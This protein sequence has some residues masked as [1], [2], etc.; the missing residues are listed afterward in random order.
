MAWDGNFETGV[1]SVPT[2]E[3]K[4]S[5]ARGGNTEDDLML[6]A[7]LIA[8]GV[9]K[10]SLAGAPRPMK[11]EDLSSSIGDGKHDAVKGS[12][13]IWVKVGNVLFCICML[14]IFIIVTLL[15]D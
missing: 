2:F 11:K 13:L 12:L 1:G 6:R 4:G 9:V 15:L 8:E 5:D 3:K 7:Q 14:V 10:I